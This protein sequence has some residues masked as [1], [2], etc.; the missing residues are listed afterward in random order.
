[1]AN[2][3]AEVTYLDEH[4]SNVQ[5][6]GTNE[7]YLETTNISLSEG[8]FLF[9]IDVEYGR[10]VAV[11]GADSRIGS[12]GGTRRRRW[13]ASRRQAPLRGR[14]AQAAGA[15]LRHAARQRRGHALLDASAASSAASGTWCSRWPRPRQD[16][17]AGER[18]HP[19]LRRARH[20]L[21]GKPDDFAI[22]RQDQFLKLYKQLTGALYGVAVGV[23]LITLIV[24]GIGI[25][26][27]MLVSVTERTREIGVRRALGARRAPSCCSSSSSP[28][29]VAALGGAV[30]TGARP[31]GGA[32]RGAALPA[33]GG[34]DAGGGGAS[35]SASRR[36]SG[37]IFG[38]W[39]AW[40][41]ANLDPVEA[42]RY[43]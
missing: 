3:N 19:I 40:R 28:R 35:A 23:G 6:R 7:Q 14:G 17:R 15:R 22:N 39:P 27:I 30:G 31:R 13:R 11:L 2:T 32:A 18:A 10:R 9:A 36:R 25:M 37:C 1:M 33:G 8:R 29:S 42:L 34:G 16:R 21:P 38:I 4:C 5:V 12:S 20:V 26:N 43:E 41:A 24:G